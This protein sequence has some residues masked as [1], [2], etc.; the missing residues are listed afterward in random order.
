[1]IILNTNTELKKTFEKLLRTMKEPVEWNG[2]FVV[3]GDYLILPGRV[4]SLFFNFE[5]RRVLTNLIEIPEQKE[6]PVEISEYTKVQNVLNLTLYAFGKWG[7]IRGIKVEKDFAQLNRLFMSV[8]QEFSVEPGYSSENFRFYKEGIRL[9]Y[10]DVVCLAIEAKEETPVLEAENEEPEAGLWHKLIW[11]K[12]ALCFTRKDTTLEERQKN[13]MG[14]N[15]YMV[16]FQCPK[17]RKNL[18][19]SVFPE[20]KEFRVETTEGGVFLARA[21]IC[22]DCH[23]FYTPRPK[24]LLSEGDVYVMDFEEDENAYEDYK[25]LL[26]AQGGRFSN[27]RYNE[28][29]E[30]RKRMEQFGTDCGQ[31]QLE[32][33]CGNIP[34]LSDE[35]LARTSEK[36]EE[37]FYR[38]ESVKKF[39]RDIRHETNKRRLKKS[40]D[41]A[42]EA[43]R[44][45][46]RSA[47][48][49][50]ASKK[51]EKEVKMMRAAEPGEES[52]QEE[53]KAKTA[54]MP[55]AS[56]IL[57]KPAVSEK[58]EKKSQKIP[59]ARRESAKKRYLAKC[60]TL[61]RMSPTQ[62]CELKNGLLQDK[63]LYQ[64]EK[65]EFLKA[66]TKKEKEQR[67]N[68]IQN[69]ILES[70]GQ[71]YGK[72]RYAA[73][74]LKK[75]DLSDKEK[76]E[77]LEPLL[78]AAK[79]Q[80]KAEVER[81]F[82]KM[83]QKM[84]L[85]QYGAYM[86][87][88]REYPDVDFK[89]YEEELRERKKQA[90]HQEISNMINR[91]R[92]A[93][94]QGLTDLMGRLEKQ[95][96]E[97]EI[98]LPY[99]EK[100]KEKLYA[101]DENAIEEICGNPRMT[102]A[103]AADA[104]EKIATGVF[105]PELKTNALEQL[106]KKLEK[107]KIDECELLVH[108]F[109]NDLDGRIAPNDRH[110]FYPARKIFTKEAALEEYGEIAYALGTYAAT[111]GMFEYPILV[112]DTSRNR[113]GKEG[114][115]LTPENLFY[116]TK[117]NAFVVP[118]REI[119]KIHSQTGMWNTGLFV[120][121]EDGTRIK[122]PCAVDRKE[123]VA[124]GNCLEKFIFYLKEKPDSRKVAY[125]AEQTHETICCF[126]CGYMYK[127][128]ST[129]PKCGYKMNQ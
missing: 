32:E 22:G 70:K 30:V 63:N 11:K 100:L 5:S 114:M 66:I 13:R 4:R 36:I 48:S 1:M 123:I 45:T 49:L 102:I 50:R 104:Y 78:A 89:P 16:G 26:G 38:A 55:Q 87:R 68:R 107:L 54:K 99:M 21:Y 88:F 101:I 2:Q 126:R 29:E 120:E 33:I 77:I 72:L 118:I 12:Q 24:K 82:A 96:F 65:E 39:E 103:E 47:D 113:S 6:P 129:C 92:A 127:S 56:Q 117:L 62:V 40:V 116:R 122:I 108:K 75:M 106:K 79:K 93:D 73:E 111:R 35:E 15:F 125:L 98:L 95:G 81:L 76:E 86:A 67:K 7:M 69:L 83:P 59:Q 71:N 74:E 115:I 97:E 37:G 17:C 8:L 124:W 25:E 91:S 58:P 112:V 80:G 85:K 121:R 9:T 90:E 14:D 41:K 64:E 52:I 110:H 57:P 18:H 34:A 94:R 20:G 84:D 19:M 23:C 128:G 27:Y 109:Q 3:I 119:K 28:F 46:K 61:D 105:L 43:A 60:R 53:Q 51:A 44:A 31:E 10:E 42:D